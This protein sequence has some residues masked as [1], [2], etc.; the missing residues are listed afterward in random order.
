MKLF[1]DHAFV[2]RINR[3]E[4]NQTYG[5][6]DGNTKDDTSPIVALPTMTKDFRVQ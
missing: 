3:D 2:N 4:P 5:N 6:L 1:L